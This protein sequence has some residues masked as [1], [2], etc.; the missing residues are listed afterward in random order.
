MP[1]CAASGARI[2]R[3]NAYAGIRIGLGRVGVHMT[4]NVFEFFA[5]CEAVEIGGD[6][7]PPPVGGRFGAAR[8][9]RRDKHVREFVE[10]AARWPPVRLGRGGILPPDIECGAAQV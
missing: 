7:A 1:A 8:T 6:R 3:G 5:S 4:D 2:T 9:V 10:R